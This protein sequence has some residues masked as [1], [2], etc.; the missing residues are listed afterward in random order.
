VASRLAG[1]S[2]PSAFAVCRLM[3]TSYLVGVC[4]GGPGC[5]ECV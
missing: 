3:A 4:T 5:N 2:R 1:T